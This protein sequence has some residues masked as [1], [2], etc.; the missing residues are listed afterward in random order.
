MLTMT[1]A[2]STSFSH[3]LPMFRMCRPSVRR[4]QMYSFM[5]LSLLRVPV[6]TPAL[7]IIWM[8]SSFGWRTS[9]RLA[10]ADMIGSR[11][12]DLGDTCETAQRWVWEDWD[13]SCLGA[14]NKQV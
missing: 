2:A 4:R 8:S 5:L 14:F 9:G 11:E 13:D 7:S 12:K 1:R 6:W 3:V 10:R